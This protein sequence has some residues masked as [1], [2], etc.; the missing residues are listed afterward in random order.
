M[1]P[2]LDKVGQNKTVAERKTETAQKMHFFE[3][4]CLQ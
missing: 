4:Y 1:F 3:I 2:K